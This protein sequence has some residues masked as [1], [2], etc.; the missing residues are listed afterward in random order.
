MT[1]IGRWVL[2]DQ[3]EPQQGGAPSDR[4]LGGP[5]AA[6]FE[7]RPLPIASMFPHTRYFEIASEKADAR[8]AIWVTT[9]IAYDRDP[10]RKFPT[11]FMPDGN[12]NSSLAASV[13]DLSDWDLMDRF[14]PT[15]Q[16]CIGYTEEDADRALAVRARDLL[17]PKEALPTGMV[18]S[19]RANA[20]NAILDKAGTD[21]YIHNLENP[22]GDRFLAFLADELYP[23]MVE[24]YRIDTDRLGL[25]GHSY[26]GLFATY[27]AL[28]PSTIFRNFG[29]SSP[30]ILFEKSVIFR[31]FADAVADGGLS[32][33]HLHMTVAT[34]EI[35]DPGV[36]QPM[37]AGGSVE[38]MRLAGTTPLKGLH[39][40]S[41]LID[42]E[43]HITVKPPAL[44]DFLRV[45]YLRQS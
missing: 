17:P 42:R 32:D 8:Y 24:N 31:M 16:V 4:K 43:T 1:G 5:S 6:G 10:Q 22:A 28:Q 3:V 33:R 37:V 29:A 25:F 35:T 40:T 39:F 21:L 11:I 38:F 26:G 27:A 9:P 30:G 14:E 12:R 20:E 45:F 23:F 15:I 18:E 34:R 36:Y 7:A 13:C 44:H 19:M 2:I 41:A